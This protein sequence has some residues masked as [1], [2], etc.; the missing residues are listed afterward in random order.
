[1][2]IEATTLIAVISGIA[3]PSLG[4][5]LWL[6]RA[7]GKLSAGLASIGSA[8][9]AFGVKLDGLQVDQEKAREARGAIRAELADHDKR[10]TLSERD[11][12]RWLNGVYSSAMTPGGR[13]Q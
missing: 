4:G 13:L 3:L 1:M 8:V 12:E 6:V 10:L 2:T 11:V 9:E 7:L 5:L